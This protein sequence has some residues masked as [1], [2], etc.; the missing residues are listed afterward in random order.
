MDPQ[1]II[2]IMKGI[3]LIG[4]LAPVAIE[5]AFKIKKVLDTD[6]TDFTVQI[7]IIRDGALVSADETLAII[8]EWKKKKGL[9]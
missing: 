3:E 6:D 8:D 7:K 5:T 1:T 2:L 9:V 4:T